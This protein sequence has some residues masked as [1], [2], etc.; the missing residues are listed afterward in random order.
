VNIFETVISIC[1]RTQSN[2]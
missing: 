1:F 2:F